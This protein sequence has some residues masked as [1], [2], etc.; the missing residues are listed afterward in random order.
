[1]RNTEAH[2]RWLGAQLSFFLN[3]PAIAAVVFRLITPPA[4]RELAI[5]VFGGSI[6]AVANLFLLQVL[7][8]NTR[9]IDLWNDKL[10]E[11]ER[12][13]GIEGGVEVFSSRRYRKLRNSRQRLHRRLE[14]AMI[15]CMVG[16]VVVVAVAT[17]MFFYF[18]G[19]LLSW[20]R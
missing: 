12:V 4:T 9:H 20:I 17:S 18:G 19:D 13:N 15:C 3:L 16:W 2:L 11:L 7:R 1:M 14:L 10:D 5:I 6:F 8:R